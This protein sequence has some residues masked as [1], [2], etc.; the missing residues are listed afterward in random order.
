M[1]K[2]TFL[3]S[4]LLVCISDLI[5]C[6]TTNKDW[7]NIKYDAEGI[8]GLGINELY[9][10]I[11]SAEL[12][13]I[14][15][16]V[17]DTG[18]D[19]YHEDLHD[20][21]WENIDEIPENGIDDDQ[22]G[23][24]DD[25]HGWNFLGNS[26][27]EN[28][29]EENLE[30]TRMYKSLQKK[31]ENAKIDTFSSSTVLEYEL[32]KN[33]EK[34]Y[35]TEYGKIQAE[36]SEY[37]QLVALYSG[38]LSYVQNKTGKD[39]LTVND[40][41]AIESNDPDEK[42]IINFLLLAE[43]EGLAAYIQETSDYF[44]NNLEYKLN[45]DFSPRE[46]ILGSSHIVKKNGYGNNQVWAGDSNHGSHVAGIIAADRN[47]GIGIAGIAR[48]A[49]IMP[50][51][52]IPIGDEYDQDIA[53]AIR[54]AADNNAR[55]INMSFGKGYSP[56]ETLVE[57]AIEYAESKGVLMI[58]A[59]GNDA[60]NNDEIVNYPRAFAEANRGNN[61]WL[62][63]AAANK[64]S[65]PSIL[66]EFSNYGKKTVDLIAPGENIYSTI[67]QNQYEWYSGTSMA[68][69]VVSGLAA[70]YWGLKPDLSARQ[71][72]KMLI[73]SIDINK[74]LPVVK[75]GNTSTLKK[76]VRYPGILKPKI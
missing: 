66:A 53:L 10:N 51:R 34:E 68:A 76:M 11:G 30:I 54:Y 2:K 62:T 12:E 22:N 44:E 23:Y 59:A 41:M 38:A 8:Q 27:G 31:F 20:A 16:A 17:I 1:I 14:V 24:I 3:L 19:I 58:H 9:E 37:T 63:V 13:E 55:I 56:L 71:I 25:V 21:I 65:S 7:Y 73:D 29:V 61:L 48:N 75:D 72:K 43:K 36:L 32:F 6:Q 42:Q 50:I 74:K 5:V 47:N 45:L 4:I 60:S 70:L 52:A 28:I 69:P 39:E 40:L 15:V 57:D 35:K 46:E 49:K 33:Y 64:L 67:S 18:V 26:K